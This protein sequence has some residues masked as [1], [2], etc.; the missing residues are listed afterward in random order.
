MTGAEDGGAQ[1]QTPFHRASGAR[2]VA[3]D[4]SS[5]QAHAARDHGQRVPRKERSLRVIEVGDVAGRMPRRG[6]DL[7]GPEQAFAVL[8]Q[9]LRFHRSWRALT[10][11]ALEQDQNAELWNAIAQPATRARA[12]SSSVELG[13]VPAVIVDR[14]CLFLLT[15]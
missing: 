9:P 8:Q 11:Q 1:R 5:H 10:E 6:N 3:C 13:L 15:L 14:R 4:C 12:S 2:D 7:E